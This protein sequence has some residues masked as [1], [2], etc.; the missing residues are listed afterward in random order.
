MET[1]CTL[2]WGLAGFQFGWFVLYPHVFKPIR[3]HLFER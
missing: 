3:D 1:L 2:G